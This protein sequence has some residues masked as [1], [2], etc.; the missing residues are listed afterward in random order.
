MPRLV[1]FQLPVP[2]LFRNANTNE[3][4]L[5]VLNNISNGQFFIENLGFEATEVTFD[6]DVWLITRNNTL[7][8]N[9]GPVAGSIHGIQC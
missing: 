5:V 8:K 3:Q 6:P 4:K 1:F 7:T 2:L 9:L